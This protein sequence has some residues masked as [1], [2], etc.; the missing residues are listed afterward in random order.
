M[1]SSM[2][3]GRILCPVDFSA[4]SR[5]ALRYA[6][7]LAQRQ[8][9]ELTVLFVNDRLLASAAAAAAYNVRRLSEET[10]SE[11]HT[12]VRRAL[13]REEIR[14]NVVTSLGDPAAEILKT[15]KTTKA[16]LVVMGSRGLTAPAKWFSGSTTEHVLR[17]TTMPVLVV[18]STLGRSARRRESLKS[19]TGPRALVPVDLK[20]TSQADVRA[21]IA[22]AKAFDATPVFVSVLPST[23]LP[24]WLRLEDSRY[25]RERIDEAN[26]ALGQLTRASRVDYEVGVGQ[27]S[28]E[29]VAA[30]KRQKAGLIIMTLKRSSSR[31]GPRRG[32]VTYQV[33]CRDVAPVLA[34]PSA[35]R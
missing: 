3:L 4:C 9:G 29:I 30:A 20:D 23:G 21:A 6:A 2:T 35:R 22:A 15:A 13:G 14:V 11:L 16:D 26:H 18:P 1:A 5:D 33:I 8:E 32:V 12:F 19:W 34:L 27:P 28:E 31:F 7:A 25:E 17:T 10:K 24:P